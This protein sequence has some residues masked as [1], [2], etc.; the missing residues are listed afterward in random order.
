VP[1]RPVP[2]HTV[3]HVV[4]PGDTF[5]GIAAAW[6][7]TLAS[8]EHANPRAGHPAGNVNNIWPGDVIRH[9]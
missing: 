5:S 7:V 8:L 6:H 3:T 4:R 9:P 1:P 2:P